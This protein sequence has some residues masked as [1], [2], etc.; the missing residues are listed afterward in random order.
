MR[1]RHTRRSARASHCIE[2]QKQFFS[3]RYR[4]CGVGV[5]ANKFAG[6][7]FVFK[8]HYA[9]NQ[10]KQRIVFAAT[11]I[12]PRFPL[13]PTLARENITAEHALAAELLESESL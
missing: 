2:F 7:T 5:H 6:T 1:A 13:G 11:D 9:V 4:S 10:S 3:L 8:F 12:V